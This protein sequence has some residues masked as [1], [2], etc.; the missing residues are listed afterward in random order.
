MAPCLTGSPTFAPN[1]PYIAGLVVLGSSMGLSLK[2]TP[3][4]PN[5]V[6]GWVMMRMALSACSDSTWIT[7]N[8]RPNPSPQAPAALVMEHPI[9]L[10]ATLD[11][12]L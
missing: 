10:S 8:S 12:S 2:L 6:A 9:V 4:H 1:P 11:G 7:G 5:T 3:G